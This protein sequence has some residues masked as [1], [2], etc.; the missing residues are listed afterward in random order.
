MAVRRRHRPSPGLFMRSTARC[1]HRHRAA[2]RHVGM[3][4]VAAAISGVTPSSEAWLHVGAGVRAS[5]RPSPAGPSRRRSAGWSC[6][7]GCAS[8]APRPR[9]ASA[10][11]RGRS[12]WRAATSNCALRLRLLARCRRLRN[13][14]RPQTIRQA[15]ARNDR[16]ECASCQGNGVSSQ[17]SAG[18]KDLHS[19]ER[20]TKT[21][22]RACSRRADSDASSRAS[23]A[24]AAPRLAEA[25]DVKTATRRLI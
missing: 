18:T 12:P 9:P 5:A 3:A 13:E 10:P 15:R 23:T 8:W 20:W 25:P 7:A 4:A 2:L 1:A 11:P 21:R 6:P 17:R 16:H 24:A 22:C 19:V 14:Q